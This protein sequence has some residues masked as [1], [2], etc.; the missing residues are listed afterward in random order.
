MRRDGLE[1]GKFQLPLGEVPSLR[2][3]RGSDTGRDGLDIGNFASPFGGS[4]ELAR[5]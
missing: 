1:V 2:G 3:D 4:A 5:R